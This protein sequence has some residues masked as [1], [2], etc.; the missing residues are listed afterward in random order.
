MQ[1]LIL[2]LKLVVDMS[3]KGQGVA[4]F[5]SSKI[6][7]GYITRGL[8]RFVLISIVGRWSINACLF[9][10]LIITGRAC[11]WSRYFLVTY[12]NQIFPF[13]VNRNVHASDFSLGFA[14]NWPSDAECENM[15]LLFLL[16]MCKIQFIRIAL[17][18]K[19]LL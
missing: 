13:Y 2:K 1:C 14:T 8:Y 5:L 7:F 17:L 11:P 18:T 10:W 4:A 9:S 19:W 6:P 16:H 12:Q 3:L 15:Y